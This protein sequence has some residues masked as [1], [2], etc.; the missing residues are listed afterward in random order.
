MQGISTANGTSTAKT[1]LLITR[2]HVI[3]N[4]AEEGERGKAQ[5]CNKI[6]I[7]CSKRL[8]LHDFYVNTYNYERETML[9]AALIISCNR[10]NIIH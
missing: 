9:P 2:G 5:Q 7:V 1:C 8:N 10:K 3:C 4:F 6:Y